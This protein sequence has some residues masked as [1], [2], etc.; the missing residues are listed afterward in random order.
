M[1]TT[2]NKTGITSKSTLHLPQRRAQPKE[3]LVPLQPIVFVRDAGGILNKIEIQKLVQ[4]S[5]AEVGGP[6]EKSAVGVVSPGGA[7]RGYEI[8]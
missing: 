6:Q 5:A 2:S 4:T 1:G 3:K 8:I 7:L